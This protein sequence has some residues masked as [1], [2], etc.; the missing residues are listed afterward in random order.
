MTRR[1]DLDADGLGVDLRVFINAPYDKYVKG[2]SRFGQASGVDVSLDT[3]GVKVN[4]E[5]LVAIL[6]GGL[7]F[8]SPPDSTDIAE[9][10]P[11]TEFRL[12]NDRTEAMKRHDRIVDTYVFNF[13]ESVRGLTV[14][15][16]VDFRAS[17]WA[18]SRRSIR[19]LTA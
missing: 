17:W 14:G 5:S 16:P 12:F 4:T 11:N 2:D 13:S 19:A 6:I 9:A 7:A 10:A 8:E 18:R 15:A 3:N 1:Y